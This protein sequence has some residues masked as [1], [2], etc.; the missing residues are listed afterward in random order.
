VA[1]IGFGLAGAVFHGPLIT[2]VPG[3]ELSAIVTRDEGRRAEA[4]ERYPQ[5]ELLRDVAEVWDRADQFDLAVIAAP[6]R[7][8][9]SLASAAIESGLVVVVDKPLA[10][11]ARAAEELVEAAQRRGLLL[12][13]F[14]NRRWD[15]DFLTVRRLIEKGELGEI[16][17]FESRFERWRPQVSSGW[18]ELPEPDEAGGLLHDLGS[19]LVDQAL[20]LFGTAQSVYAELDVRRPGA[21]VTDEVFV[22]LTHASGTRSHMW[23]SATAAQ[24]GSRFRVLGERAAY[25]KN[26]LDVQEDALRKG[27]LPSEPGWGSEDSS[28]WGLIGVDGE[29]T[30]VPTEPG[31]YQRFYEGVVAALR[32]GASPPVEPEEAVQALAVLDAA[33]DSAREGRVVD[34]SRRNYSS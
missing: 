10:V 2:A 4:A 29:T 27:G 22:A 32:E 3:L 14:Q 24:A 5:A 18:R 8:H 11:S 30:A 15:G 9:A 17:R 33:Q 31:A 26:G 7:A 21:K 12:I 20:Q 16:R 28:R 23:M 19:H 6:N 34:L 25:V 1:L 13:P